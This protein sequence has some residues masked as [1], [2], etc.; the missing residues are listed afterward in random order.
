MAIDIKYRH[1]NDLLSR[2]D[3]LHDFCDPGA[4]RN[5]DKTLNGKEAT[6][7]FDS[8]FKPEILTA[9]EKEP[10]MAEISK[11][12]LIQP[13]CGIGGYIDTFV[14]HDSLK[15]FYK[16]DLKNLVDRTQ[17]GLIFVNNMKNIYL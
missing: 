16:Q 15:G 17:N 9:M 1:F 2:L 3:T 14:A 5:K 11:R 4:D 12:T 7:E 8:V 13:F 10:K 6:D